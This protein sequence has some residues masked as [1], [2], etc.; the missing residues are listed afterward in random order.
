[1]SHRDNGYYILTLTLVMGWMKTN[2]LKLS[3]D[4]TGVL[5]VNG[6]AVW[7]LWSQP[8]WEG[9]IFSLKKQV[10]SLG[11]LLDP[12]LWLEA[13]VSSVACSTFN[14]VKLLHQL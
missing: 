3:P 1:M 7:G 4:K 5:L 9:V 6:E 2:K 14:Q 8:V 12:G 10:H 11:V 13:Q